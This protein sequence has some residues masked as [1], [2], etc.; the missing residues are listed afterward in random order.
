MIDIDR[1]SEYWI[2]NSLLKQKVNV[3][4]LSMYL[5]ITMVAAVIYFE[6]RRLV[7]IFLFDFD[8]IPIFRWTVEIVIWIWKTIKRKYRSIFIPFKMKLI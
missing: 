6:L 2:Q 3:I 7:S 1:V 5:L 8:S 4:E